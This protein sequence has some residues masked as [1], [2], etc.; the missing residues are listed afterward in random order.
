M[1]AASLASPA[2]AATGPAGPHWP[3]WADL[4]RT[5]AWALAVGVVFFSLYPALNAF[6]AGRETH[7]L[8]A[9][10]ELALPLWPPALWG[11]LSMYALFLLPPCFLPGERIGRLGRQLIAGTLLAGAVFLLLPARLGF[12]RELPPEPY[13]A[14]FALMFRLDAPHNLVPSLHVVFSGLIALACADVAR[15]W[16]R[17]VLYGWLALIGASTVLVH[18]HHLLDGVAGLA[19]VAGLRWR[20]PMR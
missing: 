14:W 6:T 15:P 12:V 2:G 9:E 20:W 8:Y 19:L 10:W 17:R 3:R 1:P 5:L 13:T 4:P 11:Y 7:A 18:Q 16:V